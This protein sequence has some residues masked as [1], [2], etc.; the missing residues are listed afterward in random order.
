MRT[1]RSSGRLLGGVCSRGC[2]PGGV[3]QGGVCRGVCLLWG[4]S[5]GECL[6]GGASQHALGQTPP[7][8]QNNWQTGVKTLPSHNFVWV[9]R[10]NTQRVTW[11][12]CTCAQ[13]TAQKRILLSLHCPAPL[14]LCSSGGSTGGGGSS[15][16]HPLAGPDSYVFMQL[17]VQFYQIIS[18]HIPSS[19]VGSPSAWQVLDSRQICLSFRPR[20]S[21]F[22]MIRIRLRFRSCDV[23]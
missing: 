1:V 16:A 13:T 4:V 5:A 10:K 6:P 23:N 19:V 15:D 7:H 12:I 14:W 21:D 9:I 20:E 2:L 22:I 11:T 8:E 3:S 17:S 18:W